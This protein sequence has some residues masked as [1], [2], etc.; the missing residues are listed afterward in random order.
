MLS[1]KIPATDSP[2]PSCTWHGARGS[3]GGAP[4]AG[5]D[6]PQMEA[7]ASVTTVAARSA[8]SWALAPSPAGLSM[9]PLCVAG[10]EPASPSGGGRAQLQ[11]GVADWGRTGAD[12]SWAE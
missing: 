5:A 2:G 8:Q 7:E 9:S 6:P 3:L 12:G 1:M 4:E 10:F 11:R